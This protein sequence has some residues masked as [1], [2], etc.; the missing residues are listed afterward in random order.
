MKKQNLGAEIG[1]ALTVPL[2]IAV[3]GLLVWA[4]MRLDGV[5]RP[6]FSGDAWSGVG[7]GRFFAF[8]GLWVLRLLTVRNPDA[9]EPP[10]ANPHGNRPLQALWNF[11]L[12]NA[13]TELRTQRWSHALGW[14][15]GALL[16]ADVTWE[17]RRF[18]A[19]AIGFFVGVG[20]VTI[21]VAGIVFSLAAVGLLIGATAQL[22]TNTRRRPTPSPAP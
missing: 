10:A 9:P 4:G 7:D 22:F 16:A 1:L 19:H 12:P 18:D 20:I 21:Y 11:G 14:L 8:A 3:L 13:Q 2:V 17:L 15:I 6:H 5:V